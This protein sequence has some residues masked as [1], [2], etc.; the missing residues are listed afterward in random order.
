MIISFLF[1]MEI[2]KE[3]EV[4]FISGTIFIFVPVVNTLFCIFQFIKMIVKITKKL[5]NGK[6]NL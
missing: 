3:I 4:P 2:D 6:N 5:Q 1:L